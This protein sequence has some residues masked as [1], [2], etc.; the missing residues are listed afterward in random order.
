[1][2]GSSTTTGARLATAEVYTPSA[3]TWANVGSMHTG[4]AAQSATL[5]S[6]G[7]VLVAGGVD[8]S[9]GLKSAELFDPAAGTWAV[10]GPMSAARFSHTST[11]LS[12]GRVLIRG[13]GPAS[14]GAE[15]YIP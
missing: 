9:A 4:R 5:L 10:T 15:L 14:P 8:M 13:G 1:V 3:N 6:S 7:K 2:G 12:S 11:L